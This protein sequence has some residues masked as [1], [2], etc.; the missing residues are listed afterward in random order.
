M[1]IAHGYLA[2]GYPWVPMGIDIHVSM[3]G[4]DAVEAL[5]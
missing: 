5:G 4:V 2:H 3:C 1:G